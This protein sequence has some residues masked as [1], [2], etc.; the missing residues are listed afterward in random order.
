VLSDAVMSFL[1]YCVFCTMFCVHAGSFAA[2][3][4]AAVLLSTAPSH[5]GILD[6]ATFQDWSM[7]A[8]VST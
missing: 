4:A 7:P 1:F 6:G 5:A 2:G 8:L 3:L